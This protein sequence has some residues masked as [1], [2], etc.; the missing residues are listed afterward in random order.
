MSGYRPTTLRLAQNHCSKAIEHYENGV[1]YDRRFFGVGIA[2]HAVLQAVGEARTRNPEA[3]FTIADKVVARL[4]TEGRTFEGEGEPPMDH[5][6]AFAGRDLALEYLRWHPFDMREDEVFELGLAVNSNF[7]RTDYSPNAYCRCILDR[8]SRYVSQE[9]DSSGARV[10]K[11]IDYKTDWPC[12][13]SRLDSLQ[14]RAQAVIYD[15]CESRNSWDIMIREVVNMRTRESWQDVIDVEDSGVI[16]RWRSDLRL[17]IKAEED[18]LDRESGARLASPGGGCIG[19]PYALRCDD[20]LDFSVDSHPDFTCCEYATVLALAKGIEPACR[21]LTAQEPKDIGGGKVVGTVAL[22][23]KVI[24]AE[25]AIEIWDEWEEK[26]G[27][28]RGFLT[29]AGGMGKGNALAIAKVIFPSRKQKK[30]REE[31]VD[32]RSVVVVKRRFGVHKK[33]VDDVE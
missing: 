32:D 4:I 27:D 21:E 29:A 3:I 26:G 1:P 7:R 12:D 6:S 5:D 31:W 16:D 2:A 11:I 23:E 18:K 15:A 14:L 17:M 33:E 10:V 30:E 20:S 8:V 22:E 13:S 19:C 25:G 24:N 28:V 9:E